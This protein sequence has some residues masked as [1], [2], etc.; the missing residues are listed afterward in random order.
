MKRYLK[1]ATAML[2]GLL[3]VMLS[4]PSSNAQIVNNIQAHIEHS[5]VIGNTTLPPGEY[6]FQMMQNSDNSVMTA[7]N[8]NDKTS[9]VFLVRSATDDHTP[10]HSEVFFRE[11]GNTEFLSKIYEGGS[12]LGA[13]V[14]EPSRQEEHFAQQGLH[15]TEHSEEQK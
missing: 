13:Q 10:K 6:T 2:V 4:A 14:T 1:A 11:Y 7:T 8:Q 5:F 3:F 9:V 12:K 15:A